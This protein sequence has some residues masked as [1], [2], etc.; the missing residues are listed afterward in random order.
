MLF[1]FQIV[2]PAIQMVYA[3]ALIIFN[4]KSHGCLYVVLY[5]LAQEVTYVCPYQGPVHGTLTLTNYRLHFQSTGK[6]CLWYKLSCFISSLWISVFVL[7]D[8]RWKFKH[9]NGVSVVTQVEDGSAHSHLMS[10]YLVLDWSI[11]TLLCSIFS[12]ASVMQ[13]ICS[14]DYTLCIS[15]MVCCEYR[16]TAC[17]T[18]RTP[19]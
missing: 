10:V 13:Y 4:S 17:C 11:K 9:K 14:G 5:I 18:C 19:L 7:L 15:Y 3:S 8:L 2:I 12:S 6:V 16:L 1:L